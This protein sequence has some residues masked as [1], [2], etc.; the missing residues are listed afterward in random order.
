MNQYKIHNYAIIFKIYQENIY[1]N[2]FSE[3]GHTVS[4]A[5]IN[6]MIKYIDPQGEEPKDLNPQGLDNYTLNGNPEQQFQQLYRFFKNKFQ[7]KFKYIDIIFTYRNQESDFVPGRPT[8]NKQQIMNLINSSQFLFRPK[9]TNITY[10]GYRKKKSRWNSGSGKKKRHHKT[11]KSKTRKNK[12][13]KR[14]DKRIQYGG[15]DEFEEAMLNVDK[16]N[17]IPSN[18]ILQ[19]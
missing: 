3:M 6:G 4:L 15:Y 13:K 16:K 19:S 1:K 17:G 14:R 2:A 8:L 11:R 7:N 9:P 12:T 5:Y 10:G 18:L